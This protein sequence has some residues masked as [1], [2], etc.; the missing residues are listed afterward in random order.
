MF[1]DLCTVCIRR[2]EQV[3]KV[4][5]SMTDDIRFRKYMYGSSTL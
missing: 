3:E 4:E 2:I 1:I 5:C